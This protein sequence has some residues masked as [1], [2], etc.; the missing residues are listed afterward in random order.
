[1]N[2]CW[3]DCSCAHPLFRSV[4]MQAIELLTD[5]YMLVQGNTVSVMGPYKGL[6]QVP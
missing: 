4:P 5:C 2:A 6:K 1:M 3:V